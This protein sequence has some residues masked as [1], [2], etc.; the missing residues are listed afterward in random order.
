MNYII[1]LLPLLGILL[2]LTGNLRTPFGRALI[3]C[4][5]IIGLVATVPRIKSGHGTKIGKTML[6]SLAG[7]VLT[8][9]LS[10]KLNLGPIVASA[11]VGLG[12]SKIFEE[13][14][15]L[16]LY[17]GAFIG[18]S[19][20]LLYP[21]RMPIIVVGLLGGLFFELLEEVCPGVGGRLGIKHLTDFKQRYIISK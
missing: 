17:L 3:F 21:T 12:G 11:L 18:M 9:F 8:L 14:E 4:M 15:Q 10:T 2:D 20:N 7:A 19:S 6:I 1:I 13:R 5:L 16:I